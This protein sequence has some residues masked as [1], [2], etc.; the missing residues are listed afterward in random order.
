MTTTAYKHV[1][2]VKALHSYYHKNLC[3]CLDFNATDSTLK[4]MHRYGLSLRKQNSGMELYAKTSQPI[5]NYL[6]HIRF[7]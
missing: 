4:L 3:T 6:A 5:S 1:L 7:W 2:T